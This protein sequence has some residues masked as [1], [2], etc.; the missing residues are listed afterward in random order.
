MRLGICRGRVV[1]GRR[2]SEDGRHSRRHG[3]ECNA[4]AEGQGRYDLRAVIDVGDQIARAPRHARGIDQAAWALHRPASRTTSATTVV[5][6]RQRM[7]RSRAFRQPQPKDALVWARA[8]FL[9]SC[10]Y[11][12]TGNA[13]SGPGC[14][15]KPDRDQCG[16][17]ECL[18]HTR[19]H[20]SPT[21]VQCDGPRRKQRRPAVELLV[22]CK[23][24]SGSVAQ[25]VAGVPARVLLEVLLWYSS[26]RV[27]RARVESQ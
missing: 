24:T 18:G 27:K 13:G 9:A 15:K 26:A 14:V 16:G 1:L 20:Q 8:S 10:V 6:R 5:S 17:S 11:E 21:C 25:V 23:S 12:S 2:S 22:S 4:Y 19:T 3:V 7:D